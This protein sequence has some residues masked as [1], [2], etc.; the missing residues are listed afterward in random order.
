MY[1]TGKNP[2][3]YY[4]V[5]TP[6]T[7]KG[8]ANEN[9]GNIAMASDN[10]L[11]ALFAAV[12]WVESGA[13]YRRHAEWMQQWKHPDMHGVI[14][15]H[16]SGEVSRDVQADIEQAL[17]KKQNLITSRMDYYKLFEPMGN[18]FMDSIG[19]MCSSFEIC[20]LTWRDTLRLDTHMASH[21][22]P[23]MGMDKGIHIPYCAQ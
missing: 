7:P 23:P 22:C 13:Q 1:A 6:T 20:T 10:R 12:Y 18:V 15:N 4:H 3:S 14:P 9:K 11:L 8:K 5:P 2:Q 21:Y 19:S 17:H 16:E